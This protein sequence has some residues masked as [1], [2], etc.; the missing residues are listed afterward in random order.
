MLF[1]NAENDALLVEA[2]VARDPAAWT[3]FVARFSGLILSS[4]ARRLKK[5]GCLVPAED[6]EDI[7]QNLLTLIWVE[8]KLE[9]VKNRKSIACWL[10]IVSGNAAMEYLRRKLADKNPKFVPITEV[11]H[12]EFLQAPSEDPGNRESLETI[13]RAIASLPPKEGLVMRLNLLCGMEY[14][15]ISEMLNMPIGT[16]SSRIMRAKNRLRK[17]LGNC[18]RPE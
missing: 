17:R 11:A 8:G 15:E 16:I 3:E 4:I 7:R 13:E 1:K 10:S 2:C 9:T 12:T 5:Y 18:Y 14:R 6:M